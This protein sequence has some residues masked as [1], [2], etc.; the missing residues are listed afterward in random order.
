MILGALR[1]KV[2]PHITKVS[3]LLLC[4]VADEDSSK[5]CSI[6]GLMCEFP[7]GQKRDKMFWLQDLHT[8]NIAVH[9]VRIKKE[10]KRPLAT[11]APYSGAR[12]E[13][14]T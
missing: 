4:A 7:R 5:R 1:A 12:T 3:N 2:L 13:S 11:L 8:A 6:V 9:A 10:A 14:I